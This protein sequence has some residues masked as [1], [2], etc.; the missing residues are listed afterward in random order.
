MVVVAKAFEEGNHTGIRSKEHDLMQLLHAVGTKSIYDG[1][2]STPPDRLFGT[3]AT[4]KIMNPTTTMSGHRQRK[5]CPGIDLKGLHW[6]QVQLPAL[7]AK[8]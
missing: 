5:F 2:I 4:G 1:W 6:H 7:M 8:L 3:T